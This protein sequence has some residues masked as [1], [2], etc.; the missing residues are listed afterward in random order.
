[1]RGAYLFERGM[2]RKVGQFILTDPIAL[3]R[4]RELEGRSR[5]GAKNGNR[6]P[7]DRQILAQCKTTTYFS[8][9][10]TN[11]RIGSTRSIGR[12]GPWSTC[13]DGC[14]G[15][16]AYM[17]LTSTS[18]GAIKKGDRVKVLFVLAFGRHSSGG[19]RRFGYALRRFRPFLFARAPRLRGLSRPGGVDRP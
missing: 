1:M 2:N 8:P 6:R 11:R 4:R 19:L 10:R 7:R 3:P 13:L 9:C 14:L 18:F 5:P 16:T 17:V 15:R 12:T